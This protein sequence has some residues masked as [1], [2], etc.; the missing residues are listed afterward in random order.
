MS[1][2]RHPLTAENR[3]LRG[4]PIDQAVVARL[5]ESL[6]QMT[7]PEDDLAGKFYQALFA[8]HPALRPMFPSDMTAQKKKLLDALVMVIEHLRS[9][10]IVRTRLHQLGASHVGY[11]ARPE[12][13]PLVCAA[14]VEAM[15]KVSGAGWDDDLALEWR[16]ALDLVSHIMLEGAA[17]RHR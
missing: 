12:H 6:R 2:T 15:T 10:E 16:T 17:N 4:V 8:R 9:P 5:Q 14:I 1:V 3:H 7:A 11:G 13:Y